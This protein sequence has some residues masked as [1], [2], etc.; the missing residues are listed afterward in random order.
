M[1]LSESL[2]LL[3]LLY[4][5]LNKDAGEEGHEL[6]WKYVA[7]LCSQSYWAFLRIGLGYRWMDPY[8][9]GEVISTFIDQ[10]VGND[11]VVILPR[12]SGKTAMIT[13]PYPVW[14]IC[15]N[16]LLL[17]QI[18]NAAEDKARAFTKTVANLLTKTPRIKKLYPMIK[19]AT[20]AWSVKGYRLDTEFLMNQ[21]RESG[22]EQ[23]GALDRTDPTL[24]SYGM[25]GN[26]TGAHVGLQLHDDL[27]THEIARSPL[28]LERCEQFL[29][30]AFRCC[31]AHGEIMIAGTR[32]LYG[33]YYGKILEG[34]LSA[35][36]GPFKVLKHGVYK[37]DGSLVW[38][39]RTFFDMSG[40]LNMAGYT[41]DQLTEAKK[42][43]FFSA[44]YLCEPKS[45]HESV[46]D[47]T[48]V[49]VFDTLPFPIGYMDFVCFEKEGAGSMIAENFSHQCRQEGRHEIRVT[50]VSSGRKLSKEAKIASILGTEVN[51]GR[52]HVH[53]TVWKGNDNLGD[54]MRRFGQSVGHDD[55]L[56]CCTYLAKLAK[57]PKPNEMPRPV[58]I[59][60]PGFTD[61]K[62]S[63]P[64][65]I[66]CGVRMNGDL[67]ILDARRIRTVRPEVLSAEIFRMYYHWNNAEKKAVTTKRKVY[68]GVRGFY[69]LTRGRGNQSRVK[70][71]GFTVDLS[72]LGYKKD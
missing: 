33:D 61:K 47:V 15:Q 54:E 16:P 50:T 1:K 63:D 22:V 37:P 10:N 19:P 3:E 13:T 43:S 28:L 55:L 2:D 34:D 71:G 60:D 17:C 58:I 21:L 62:Q 44:L 45:E 69:S 8:W 30:E 59:I 29:K 66:V 38:P 35:H 23:E 48:M 32:W 7:K 49:N 27:I 51:N 52:L 56:D 20:G 24:A 4:D 26:I 11:K 64:T 67:W 70:E 5:Q 41:E 46:L 39:Q 65:A 72:L 40:N 14:K 31:D 9:H 12:G 36:K 53:R 68:N 25:R 18:T 42:D 6:W 57:E